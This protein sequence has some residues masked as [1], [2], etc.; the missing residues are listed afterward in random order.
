MKTMLRLAALALFLTSCS[1]DSATTPTTTPTTTT[2]TTAASPTISETFTGRVPVAG[3]TFF[4]FGVQQYGTINVTFTSITGTGV[5]ATVQMRVGLG[6]VTE[7]SCTASTSDVVR[8]GSTAQLTVI[9]D[10]GTYCVNVTDIGNLF[11]DA[12]VTVV[13]DHP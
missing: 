1:K 5:P 8:P 4:T 2:T 10:V 12:T 6:V 7:T 3:T 13:V 9:K 11:R